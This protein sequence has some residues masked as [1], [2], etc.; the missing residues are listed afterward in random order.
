MRQFETMV[1]LSPD[2]TNEAVEEQITFFENQV[3]EG[4]GEI[5]N[6]DRW[7]KKRL[8]YPINRQRHGI[9]YVI[10][11]KAEPATVQEIER[12]FRLK[13]DNWR[14]MTVRR[15]P[16]TL[17]KMAKDAMRAA[18]HAEHDSRPKSGDEREA[19]KLQ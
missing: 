17:R 12:Q 10:S 19:G 5:L 13:E 16:G 15:D 6:I 11:Y 14:Y 8:A 9:Y 7:G 1:L 18:A 3:N 4:G 2:M